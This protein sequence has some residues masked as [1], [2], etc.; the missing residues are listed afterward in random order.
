MNW[1]SNIIFV[2]VCHHKPFLLNLKIFF[3]FF[4]FFFQRI[5]LMSNE[6][7]EDLMWLFCSTV[8]APLSSTSFPLHQ[9]RTW[10]LLLFVTP[11]LAGSIQL[12]WW[13]SLIGQR[14]EDVTSA[15][16]RT[17]IYRH[18][19][20]KHM[21]YLYIFLFIILILYYFVLL[22]TCS[23]ND[24]HGCKSMTSSTQPDVCVQKEQRFR[25]A[26]A[27]TTPLPSWSNWTSPLGMFTCHLKK[28]RQSDWNSPIERSSLVPFLTWDVSAA[29]GSSA[30]AT[31]NRSK[32]V[33]HLN[34]V[35]Q[36]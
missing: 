30:T 29:I 23:F 25:I 7:C 10:Y 21:K 14:E 32:Q 22:L 26:V 1:T 15:T 4:F 36:C 8:P 16:V 3:L 9:D 6:L 27:M 24:F 19:L 18:V 34:R 5:R 31:H 33:S 2:S 13:R 12:S 28:Q 17:R 11:P 20:F 35:E